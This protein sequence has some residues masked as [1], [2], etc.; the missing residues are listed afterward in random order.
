MAV[1]VLGIALCAGCDGRRTGVA[2]Q[3][4]R[5]ALERIN[6]NFA[7]LRTP[8]F[9]QGLVSFRYRDASETMRNYVAHPTTL[10]FLAPRCLRFDIKSPLAGSVARVGSSDERYWLWTEL[11]DERKLYLGRWSQVRPDV[12]RRLP[13]PPTDLLDALL[14]RPLPETLAGGLKPI[15][16]IDG[17]DHRLLFFRLDDSKQTA[18]L[19]EFVL[20]P[21]EPYLPLQIIDRN[22]DGGVTMRAALSQYTVVPET[23][24]YTPR[25]YVIAWPQR[26]AE[27]RLDVT[28][29]RL[30]SDLPPF[31]TP[32]DA[33]S[34]DGVVEDLDPVA[35]A[36]S[37]ARE[38][39][40][41]AVR[42]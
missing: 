41:S 13:V 37:R 28:E 6:A 35:P 42:W 21:A 39:A 24:I 32:P 4:A 20:D 1:L 36:A 15:L 2:P 8:I 17:S 5:E 40:A 7:A 31:C 27:L 33:R 10:A 38:P 25:R 30:R 9:C 29:A 23:T 19:R 3:S 16:R 26:D 34:F 12:L 11:G 18:A 22:P 14:L